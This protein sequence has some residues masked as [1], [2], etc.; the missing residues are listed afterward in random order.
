MIVSMHD[1]IEVDKTV[2]EAMSQNIAAEIAQ[3]AKR[4]KPGHWTFI[5][6]GSGEKWDG[7]MADKPDGRWDSTAEVMMKQSC[8][9]VFRCE[10]IT[11]ENGR[12]SKTIH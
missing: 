7:R 4:F 10:S 8:I 11:E 5:A 6:L 9:Q 2:N 12:K 3:F 1:D